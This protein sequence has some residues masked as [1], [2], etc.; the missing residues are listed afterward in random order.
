M[1][2]S[3]LKD[4]ETLRWLFESTFDIKEHPYRSEGGEA[5]K[6]HLT[7]CR[8]IFSAICFRLEVTAPSV[9]NSQ[10]RWQRSCQEADN[11]S[12]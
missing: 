8:S 10:R 3:W 9:S 11:V 6:Y 12:S 4:S 5:H 1:E 2:E 7:R